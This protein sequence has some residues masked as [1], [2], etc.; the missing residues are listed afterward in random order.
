MCLAVSGEKFGGDVS[1][2]ER[3]LVVMCLAVSGEKFGAD[4]SGGV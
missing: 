2:V 1:G 3:S 4:V